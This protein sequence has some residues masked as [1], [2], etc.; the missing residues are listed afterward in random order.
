MQNYQEDK[1]GEFETA[2]LLPVDSPTPTSVLFSPEDGPGHRKSS[3]LS[4]PLLEEPSSKGEKEVKRRKKASIGS[5]VVSLVLMP[6]VSVVYLG[7]CYVVHFKTV[8]IDVHVG[9]DGDT[10]NSLTVIKSGVTSVSVLIISLA[11]YPVKDL[12]SD[13]KSEEFFRAVSDRPNGVP[14]NSI[15]AI[16]TPSFGFYESIG[17]M[18]R[19][20]ASIQFM[21]AFALGLL[22]LAASTLASAA[23][24]VTTILFDSDATG[25]RVGAMN[26]GSMIDTFRGKTSWD[27]HPYGDTGLTSGAFISISS[28]ST[29]AWIENVMNVPSVFQ[30]KNSTHYIVPA[31][32]NLPPSVPARW[33][34]DVVVMKPSCFWSEAKINSTDESGVSAVIDLERGYSTYVHSKV[35]S[36]G[37]QYY[38]GIYNTAD[39]REPL[40][41]VSLW[42]GIG[43]TGCTPSSQD[44]SLDQSAIPTL[45]VTLRSI[46]PVNNST[47]EYLMSFLVCTPN[48]TV[49]TREVRNDGHG[50]LTIMDFA[51]AT[52]Q[53][54]LDPVQVN[55]MLSQS[56]SKLYT[57][58]GPGPSLQLGSQGQIYMVFGRDLA[59]ESLKLDP[60]STNSATNSNTSNSAP[61]IWKPAPIANISD[62]Y[63]H[64]L[65]S[66]SRSFL[67]GQLDT[68]Y[69]P[70]MIATERVIFA[71]SLPHVIASTVIFAILIAT[72]IVM[73]FRKEAAQF[74][75]C[76]VA[77]SLD[78]S[79]VPSAAAEALHD[80]EK[81]LEAY[82]LVEET[83]MGQR[84]VVLVPPSQDTHELDASPLP[85]LRLR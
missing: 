44:P 31:P 36:T 50:G 62:N 57:D 22:V 79:N 72:S 69:V 66:S 16:S 51:Q 8:P 85:V 78:G 61:L 19:K 13:L 58:G 68:A 34:T 39:G 76:A 74:T 45:N 28:A 47:V 42:R 30:A 12:I 4:R 17:V 23:L 41:G 1:T 2:Q 77:A 25:L 35:T 82:D 24:S 73:F 5:I 20:H 53:R 56:L 37:L 59:T 21:V 75:F 67:N 7:F 38:D 84:T 43:C 3:S 14:L 64:F 40:D 48:A 10:S 32:M 26:P 27:G 46:S 80:G 49:Q 54:N 83:T 11:L 60:L 6:L 55:A 15:N 65:V 18:Y 52:P 33:L 71:S 81:T 9:S 63:A 29:M 70:A